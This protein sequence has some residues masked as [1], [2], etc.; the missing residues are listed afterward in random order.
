M[1]RSLFLIVLCAAAASGQPLPLEGIAHV[2]Y[3]V[4]DQA[5]SAAY[6][7]GI[8]GLPVAFRSN[9][10]ADFFKVS[11]D[12]YVELDRA[13]ESSAPPFHIALQTTDIAVLRRLLRD[14]GVPAPKAAKD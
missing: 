3:G 4:R 12:Q 13:S 2:G 6:Y 1:R 10:G 7:T 5:K 9:E 11:D 8:L 14:R